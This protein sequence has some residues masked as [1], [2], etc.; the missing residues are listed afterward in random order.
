M[1]DLYARVE[2][3]LEPEYHLFDIQVLEDGPA[4]FMALLKYHIRF[5]Q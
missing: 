2:I 5:Q 3:E 1:W 4:N